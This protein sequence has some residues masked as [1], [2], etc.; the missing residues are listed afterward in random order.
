M[1]KDTLYDALKDAERFARFAKK[2]LNLEPQKV[3]AYNYVP[4]GPDSAQVKRSS[5]DLT[6]ALARI[7]RSDP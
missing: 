5:M 7:R 6:R 4:A 2:A 3:G 1:R